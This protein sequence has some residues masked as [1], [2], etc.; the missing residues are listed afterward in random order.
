[1]KTASQDVT[2][3][4]IWWKTKTMTA[5]IAMIACAST[6]MA[7]H[8]L[9][10]TRF[11]TPRTAENA[12][13]TSTD[14]TALTWTAVLTV[15][16]PTTQTGES[17]LQ[18]VEEEYS[19]DTGVRPTHQRPMVGRNALEPTNKTELATNNLAQSQQLLQQH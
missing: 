7:R 10:G 1:M 8:T 11:K 5:F 17:V 15:A 19:T 9:K 3:Q 2:A 18:P 6:K 4:L 13:V 16:G 14:S 12:N